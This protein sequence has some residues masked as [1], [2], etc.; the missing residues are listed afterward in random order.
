MPLP[1]GLQH[2]YRTRYTFDPF[3]AN[4]GCASRMTGRVTMDNRQI[5]TSLH[6]SAQE[7]CAQ[8]DRLSAHL[9]VKAPLNFGFWHSKFNTHPTHFRTPDTPQISRH[10][11]INH[12]KKPTYNYTPISSSNILHFYSFLSYSHRYFRASFT[13]P[14][15]PAATLGGA[16]RTTPRKRRTS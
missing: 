6:I 3:H 12:R 7:L 15:G 11:H 4:S 16:G 13:L 8:P 1:I 5:H 10:L 2:R 14:C 9:K